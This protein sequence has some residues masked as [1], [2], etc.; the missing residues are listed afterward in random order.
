MSQ[1]AMR[2]YHA[3]S[4]QKL[5][6][7]SETDRQKEKDR[8]RE[9]KETDT[10]GETERQE[11]ERERER[12]REKHERYRRAEKGSK[13]DRERRRERERHS[14]R[15]R[16][17]DGKGFTEYHYLCSTKCSPQNSKTGGDDTG[18]CDIWLVN[19]VQV[20]IRGPASKWHVVAG[21]IQK[22]PVP[23]L[24]PCCSDTEPSS[25]GES[26]KEANPLSS[27]SQQVTRE[28]SFGREQK[29]DDRLKHCW[30]QV[31]QA[32][33]VNTH[34]GNQLPAAYFLV[35]GGLL[36]Y[37]TKCCG[38][39]CDLLVVPHSWTALLM[40]LAHTH[41]LGG[42]LG[43]CNTLEKLKDRFTSPGMKAEVQAFSRACP[44]CQRMAPQKPEPPP[45][46]TPHHR[47]PLRAYRHGP[48]W[49]AA[50][51]NPFFMNT[52]W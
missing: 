34:Q 27:V 23:M 31:L 28:G 47:R 17:N 30:G 44:R 6:I 18:L 21:V 4:R 39:P 29:E 22:L 48:C 52:S 1:D 45:Y 3:E 9:K 5:G 24:P 40:H 49:A 38:E 2:Q 7:G 51:V 50:K 37:C 36:Y 8:E 26:E 11:R 35:K 42:H 41:P 20:L 16:E 10:G 12:E 25:P 15:K 19:S 13:R 32:E 14:E 33:G 43:P 46:S